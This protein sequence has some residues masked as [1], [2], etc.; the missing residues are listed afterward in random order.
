MHL[1]LDYLLHWLGRTQ[2]W[3]LAEFTARRYFG[4]YCS[5]KA[6]RIDNLRRFLCRAWRGTWA[7][8]I[9]PLDVG[10][11]VVLADG[12]FCVQHLL[13]HSVGFSN[14]L[15]VATGSTLRGAQIVTNNGGRARP[16]PAMPCDSN[17]AVF[18]RQRPLPAIKHSMSGACVATENSLAWRMCLPCGS[19][20]ASHRLRDFWLDGRNS[21]CN[22]ALAEDEDVFFL[23]LV[24]ILQIGGGRSDIP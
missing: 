6:M 8:A 3:Q 16:S 13:N 24:A 5:F 11:G 7:I 19:I 14:E 23:Y 21:L 18:N 15:S 10:G 20:F 17:S 2:C 9:Q 22:D 12:S 1:G 4:I